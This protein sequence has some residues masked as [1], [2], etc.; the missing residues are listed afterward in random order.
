M[1]WAGEV[2]L[3]PTRPEEEL[4]PRA[5]RHPG[6]GP[7]QPKH[8]KAHWGLWVVMLG[9]VRG[10]PGHSQERGHRAACLTGPNSDD[11]VAAAGAG[12]W[13]SLCSFPAL[14][15]S[16]STAPCSPHTHPISQPSWSGRE[17]GCQLGLLAPVTP[18]QGRPRHR[19]CRASSPAS[20][21]RRCHAPEGGKGPTKS[22][23]QRPETT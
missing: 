14:G 7:P 6:A 13:A 10:G 8:S 22:C 1:A 9:Q 19:G 3:S 20:S 17:P 4:W 21:W 11:G 5:G 18:Q 15:G 16:Y 2:Q 12:V 23:V